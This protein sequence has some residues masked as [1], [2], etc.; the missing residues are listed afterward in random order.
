MVDRLVADLD[1]DD[2]TVRER[3][4]DEL[5]KFGDAITPDLRRALAKRPPLEV[6]R[7]IQQQLDQAHDWTPE[8]LRDHRA[9][10]ALEHIGTPETR[11]LLEALAG[12]A[13]NARRTEEAKTALRRMGG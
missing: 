9:I 4:T 11:R 12:G 3:A 8:R 6:R 2:F 5:S 10:Q 1:S 13:S 7:R